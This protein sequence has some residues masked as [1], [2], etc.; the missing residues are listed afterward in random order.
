M[1][2]FQLLFI[3]T[4]IRTQ[5]A[6]TW[7]GIHIRHQLD[8]NAA[9]WTKNNIDDAL[10]YFKA[11]T[12]DQYGGTYSCWIDGVSNDGSTNMNIIPSM[13]GFFI[14]VSNGTFPVTGTLGMNNSVRITDLN[15]SFTKSL[16]ISSSPPL[17]R[18]SA[19]FSDDQAS[20][21]R[22]VIYFDEKATPDFDSQLDAL[23]LLNTD[24]AVSNLYTVN[25][26]GTKLSISAL[27][28]VSDNLLQIPLGLKLNRE[29]SIIFRIRDIDESLTG[30]RIYITDITAGI[31]QDLLPDKK[32]RVSL[33]TGEYDNRFFLN[34]SDIETGIKDE[35]FPQRSI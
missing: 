14:H 15:H 8:W 6:S 4:I 24:W 17:L 13:Q 28:P 27:P 22:A 20:A 34:F 35:Y 32:Y 2:V 19:E 9:G 29:G 16:N 33:G 1:E 7:L 26:D 10:Y 12:T 25:P 11:S 30:I 21:D 31:D 5:R 18:L 23:K 3:I